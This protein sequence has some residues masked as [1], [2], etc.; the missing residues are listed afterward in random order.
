MIRTIRTEEIV[1]SIREM[2]IEANHYLS[3]DMEQALNKAKDTE[4][5]PLGKKILSQLQENLSIAKEELIPICQ[6]T[7]MAVVF[8]EI[9]QDVHLDGPVLEEAVNEGVR[10]GYADGYLRKSV[11]KDPIYRDNTKDNTPAVL[12]CFI[13]KG[14]KVKLWH[15]KGLAART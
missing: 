8:A 15:R 10:Q 3:P 14:D 1:R 4:Q 2:C 11:V 9:G 12:H 5:S 6:D 13:V 7:G